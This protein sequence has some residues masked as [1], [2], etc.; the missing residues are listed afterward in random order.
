MVSRDEL[1]SGKK[2]SPFFSLL[3]PWRYSKNN[4]EAEQTRLENLRN[5]Q[6]LRKAIVRKRI[7]PQKVKKYRMHHSV[8]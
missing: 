4:R 1:G 3:T 6:G 5:R 2:T 7:G 8:G